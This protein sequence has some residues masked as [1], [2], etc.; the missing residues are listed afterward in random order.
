MNNH[1]PIGS[2]V[3]RA[4]NFD[5]WGWEEHFPEE[6]NEETAIP[7]QVTDSH[8]I[9]SIRIDNLDHIFHPG[10]FELAGELE[11]MQLHQHQAAEAASE[12]AVTHI[13]WEV[14]GTTPGTG[15]R[16]TLFR[17]NPNTPPDALI[18]TANNMRDRG[19]TVIVIYQVFEVGNGD[20]SYIKV[21]EDAL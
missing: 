18:G 1:F 6:H 19:L 15:R 2:W 8:G 16:S 12:D 9:H 14:R 13:G 21:P 20:L 4:R 10:S 11:V 5:W 17:Q 3:V 7:H